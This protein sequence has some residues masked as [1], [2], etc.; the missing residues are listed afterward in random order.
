MFPRIREIIDENG[1]RLRVS[2][3][4][5]RGGA[6]ITLELPDRPDVPQ[7][8]LD[9]LAAELLSSFIMSARLALPHGLPDEDSL[10]GLARRFHLVVAP[11]P[12]IEVTQGAGGDP[13]QVPAR[14]WDRLYAE[15]CLIIAHTRD[16]TWHVPVR[17]Q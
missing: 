1:D 11:N 6:L 10:R 2:V 17:L 5:D 8:A 9:P 3:V 12:L 13:F 14:Y 16:L 4:A 15:L 7:V